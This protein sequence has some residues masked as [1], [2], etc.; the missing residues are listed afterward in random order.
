MDRHV[1]LRT[2]A[3]IAAGAG[4]VYIAHQHPNLGAALG[5]GAIVVGLLH[6]LTRGQ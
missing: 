4:A 6:E 1:R 5:I 2:L 3:L